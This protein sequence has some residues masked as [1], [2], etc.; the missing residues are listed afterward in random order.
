MK[1]AK[2]NRKCVTKNT[3]Y[4]MKF[5]AVDHRVYGRLISIQLHKDYEKT[6]KGAFQ[7]DWQF[8]STEKIALIKKWKIYFL[9]YVCNLHV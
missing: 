9:L 2:A 8:H 1:R 5:L 7:F 4:G 3:T 6:S